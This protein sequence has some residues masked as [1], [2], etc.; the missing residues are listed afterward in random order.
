MRLARLTDYGVGILAFMAKAP[1]E[2]YQ[3]AEIAKATAISRP[4]A[5]KLLKILTQHHF[6][7]SHRGIKGGYCL[8]QAPEKTSLGSI[9]QAMEGPIGLTECAASPQHSC[10]LRFQCHMQAPWLRVNHLIT[11]VLDTIYLSDLIKPLGSFTARPNFLK[12]QQHV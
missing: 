3:S 9:I 6:L 12:V 5:A 10:D 1:S 7:A 2:I 11:G 4:T 8:S